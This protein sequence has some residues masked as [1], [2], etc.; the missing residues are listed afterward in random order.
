VF[1]LS[2][3]CDIA[4]QIERNGEKAYREAAERTKVP[5]VARLL[6]MLAED[7]AKHL[8]WFEQMV[9]SHPVEIK[10][11][12]IA[13]IGRELLQEMMAPQ[14]FSLDKKEMAAADSPQTMLHQSIEFE[15]DTI[16]FYE[17]LSGFLDDVNT[18]HQLDLIITEERSHI[19]KLNEILTLQ[20]ELGIRV[21]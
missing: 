17:M 16:L 20:D 12:Q 11:L 1:T 10:D 4:V 13:Q 21:V 7:E 9:V 2:D 18:K 8:Q 5:E 3:I 19:D 6:E 15:K 14:T